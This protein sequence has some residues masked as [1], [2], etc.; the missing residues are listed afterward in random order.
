MSVQGIFAGSGEIGKG[1]KKC[2][3]GTWENYLGDDGFSLSGMKVFCISDVLYDVLV[4]TTLLPSFLNSAWERAAPK[5]LERL[6]MVFIKSITGTLAVVIMVISTVGAVA[7][8]D[9]LSRF[10]PAGIWQA[11]DGDSRYDVT[12]CGDGTQICAKL[13]WIKPDKINNRN[14]QYLDK[15]VIYEGNRVRPAE[16]RGNID[17]YGVSVGG[18]VKIVNQNQLKVTGCAFGFFCQGFELFRIEERAGLS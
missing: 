1:Q 3:T 12:L 6:N 7:N 4:V 17:I 11:D 5:A 14:I 2:C 9:P 18:S 16:W 15:Y 8:N 13:I 10:S